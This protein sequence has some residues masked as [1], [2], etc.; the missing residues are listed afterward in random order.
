MFLP[1]GGYLYFP[2]VNALLGAFSCDFSV[3]IH[4]SSENQAFSAL[5]AGKTGG[6]Y[7]AKMNI[8]AACVHII[9]NSTFV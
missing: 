1:F 2:G 8:L 5:G 9:Q 3:Y 6:E 4:P 7:D